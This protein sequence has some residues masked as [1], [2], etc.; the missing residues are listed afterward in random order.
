MEIKSTSSR[1]S[2]KRKTTSFN[3]INIKRTRVKQKVTEE[4][5]DKDSDI[6]DILD[7]ISEAALVDNSELNDTI[8][9]LEE[10]SAKSGRKKEK[11]EQ[12]IQLKLKT[13][14]HFEL[15]L[16]CKKIWEKIRQKDCQTKQREELLSQLMHLIQKRV[17]EIIF[18]HDASRIIQCAIK[19]GSKEQRVVIAK[20]LE[21][22]FVELTR[23]KYGK[24]ILKSLLLH[25]PSVRKAIHSELKGNVVQLI[26]HKEASYI[27]DILYALYSNAAERFLL[28]CEFYSP[29]FRLFKTPSELSSLDEILERTPQKKSFIINYILQT[30]CSILNKGTVGNQIVHR[31]M[32][33]FLN[34]AELSK[35]QELV[36]LL[37]EQIP[38]IV[39]TKEG[40][41]VAMLC[42]AH[43]HAKTRKIIIR[44]LKPYLAKIAVEEYGYIV[45]VTALGLIDDTVFLQKSIVNELLKNPVEIMSDKA[46]RRIFLFLIEGK[47]SPTYFPNQ[48]ITFFQNCME[49]SYQLETSKKPVQT[50]A[51]ELRSGILSLWNYFLSLDAVLELWLQSYPNQ[52]LTELIIHDSSS[53]EAS[54]TFEILMKTIDEQKPASHC[55]D[56]SNPDIYAFY[57]YNPLLIHFLQRLIKAKPAEFTERI[58]LLISS[59]IDSLLNIPSTTYLL[60][61]LIEANIDSVT[62]P[63][64]KQIQCRPEFPSFSTSSKAPQRLLHE[65]I[66]ANLSVS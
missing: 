46:G 48:S 3:K 16:Q 53:S 11:K 62:A 34:H 37:K 14:P 39:H 12:L 47:L 29:E 64:I 55:T 42:I 4:E 6:S 24:F 2:K 65:K 38:E 49:I 52:I 40:S 63:L 56:P 32:L 59:H 31:V 26:K 51:D 50:R 27:L 36:E 10:T 1:N 41:M 54:Q 15:I 9:G 17:V 19:Y 57:L 18:K 58:Y 8:K 35:I 33:D 20:E 23:S 61:N 22:H 13:K 5:P 45:L 30:L 60:V 21:G 43:A 44:S 25:C 66:T 28:I 7:S